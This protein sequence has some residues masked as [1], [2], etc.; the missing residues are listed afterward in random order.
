MTFGLSDGTI[1]TVRAILE[2]YPA[3]KAAILYGSRAK[4]TERSGSDIDL[5]LVGADLTHRMLLRIADRLDDS[6]VPYGFDLCLLK[7]IGDPALRNHIERRGVFLYQRE[8][9]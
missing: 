6:M 9:H 3:V 5:A 8:P 4:G 1:E 2:D 7:D